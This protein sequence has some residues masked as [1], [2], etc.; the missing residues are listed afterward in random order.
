MCVSFCFACVSALHVSLLLA[1]QQKRFYLRSCVGHAGLHLRCSSQTLAAAECT[2]MWLKLDPRL[3]IFEARCLFGR[4]ASG[5]NKRRG[6][7]VVV[8]GV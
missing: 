8:A 1:E 3:K 6:L 5:K 7:D 4:C 2:R